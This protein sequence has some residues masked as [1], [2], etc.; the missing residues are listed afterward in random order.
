MR[1]FK[2]HRWLVLLVFFAL[3]PASA[4]GMYPQVLMDYVAS[5]R[6]AT[7][8]VSLEQFRAAI[9][10]PEILIIDVR[11]PDEYAAGHIPNAVNIPRG[12]IEFM[13]WPAVGYPDRTDMDKK[14]YLY[15]QS[16][17]RCALAARALHD[18]GFT[19]AYRTELNIKE[20]AE[21]GNALVK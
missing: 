20:W 11:E 19:Q 12:V 9:D 14:M 21:A 17:G 8:V 13:I 5:A 18:L 2:C 10:D 15:C 6:G 4:A 1:F 3:S 7:P 16:G